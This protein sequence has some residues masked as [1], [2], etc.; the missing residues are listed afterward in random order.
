MVEK[1]N[2]PENPKILQILIQTPLKPPILKGQKGFIMTSPVPEYNYHIP[3]V[4]YLNHFVKVTCETIAWINVALIGVIITQVVMRY[5]FNNG[6]VFLEEL[7]WHLYAIAF[8]FGISYAMVNDAHIRVDIVHMK[9]SRRMKH[10][11]EIF[12][13]IVFLLPFLIII[14]LQSFD[15]VLESY[16]LNES[17]SDPTGLPYRWLIKAVIPLSFLL[18]TITTLSRLIQEVLLLFHYG[19]E[20]DDVTPKHVSMLRHLFQVQSTPKQQ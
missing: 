8:M 19:K 4:H 6:L 15:W 1:Q 20:Q 14:G 2:C 5:G 16:R 12:G 3:V 11:W 10:F 13:I 9:L 17:S 18:L 7:M